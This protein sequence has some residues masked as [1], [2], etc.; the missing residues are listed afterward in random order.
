MALDEAL[1]G[2]GGKW[3]GGKEWGKN[4]R[5]EMEEDEGTRIGLGQQ[6]MRKESPQIVDGSTPLDT[7][8]CQ[9]VMSIDSC[10]CVYTCEIK[11][12]KMFACI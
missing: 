2:I 5:R 1:R 3:K 9:R 6:G 4:G 7:P 11:Q 10:C 12:S 8:M